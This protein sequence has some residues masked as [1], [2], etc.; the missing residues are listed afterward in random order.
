M[1]SLTVDIYHNKNY[2]L[3]DIESLFIPIFGHVYSYSILL[4]IS[5]HIW[6]AYI[7]NTLIGCVLAKK[8]QNPSILYLI[9]FGIKQIYQTMGI[10]SHLLSTIINYS[11]KYFYTNIYLHT[12]CTNERAIRFYKKFHFYIDLFIENYY[13]TMLTFYSHAFQM[14]LKL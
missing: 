8:S 6:S 14:K 4:N 3:N 13:E 7:N 12:E 2:S 1:N 10:G 11:K 5:N 9:L